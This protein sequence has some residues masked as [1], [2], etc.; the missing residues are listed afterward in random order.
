M[1]KIVL[2]KQD[3]AA[4]I[5][6]LDQFPEINTIEILKH[7]NS[8]IGYTIDIKFELTQNHVPGIFTTEVVGTDNW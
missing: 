7:D 1:N 2:T 3:L 4:I 6:T 8:G 5:N